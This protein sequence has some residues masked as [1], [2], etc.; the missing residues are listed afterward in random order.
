MR[1]EA[2]GQSRDRV[3]K[4]ERTMPGQIADAE[5]ELGLGASRAGMAPL[6][7]RLRKTYACHWLGTCLVLVV[8]QWLI[9]KVRVQG[10]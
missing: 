7:R 6:L 5:E 8:A 10:Q 3:P 1:G 9:T 2:G 4:P